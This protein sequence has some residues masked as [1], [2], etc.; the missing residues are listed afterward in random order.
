[1][2]KGDQR[3]TVTDYFVG[4][5]FVLCHANI[6]KV[7]QVLISEKSA[8][9]GESNG[10]IEVDAPELFGGYD[11]EGGAIGTL[12]VLDGNENQAP[13]S[14][15]QQ[16]IGTP[17]PAYRGITTVVAEAFNVG[18]NYYM[19]SWM[20]DVV[21]IAKLTSGAAQ[22]NIGT[23]EV[24]GAG[25]GII[26]AVHVIM[27][28]YTD[29]SW[30]K[31]VS[32][33]DIDTAS[34]VTAA[35]T[36]YDEG[37]GFS[38]E[39]AGKKSL[40]D[41]ILDVTSHIQGVVRT[42][43]TTQQI[44]LF[45]IR[46]IVDTSGLLL[47]DETNIVDVSSITKRELDKRVSHLVIK[48]LPIGENKE[49]T[50]TFSSPSLSLKQIKPKKKTTN[51]T[52]VVT[53]E[54]AIKLGN[55]DMQQLSRPI[56]SGSFTC[57]P[58]ASG[59]NIGDAFKLNHPDYMDFTI[60]CRVETLGLG[61]VE[62]SKLTLT[63]SED[64]Y[65]VSSAVYASI[66]ASA[67]VDPIQP[68]VNSPFQ[69]VG[70]VPYYRIAQVVGDAEARLLDYTSEVGL[71]MLL[72]APTGDTLSGDMYYK[73]GGSWI[74][75]GGYSAQSTFAAEITTEIDQL[76]ATVPIGLVVGYSYLE[77]G[78]ILVV[79]KEYMSVVTL[80]TTSLVV[81]RGVLSSYPRV[82]IAGTR[83]FSLSDFVTSSDITTYG[84][85]TYEYW[86]G[87]V[88]LGGRLAPEAGTTGLF[89]DPDS[90]L[91]FDPYPPADLKIGGVSWLAS[92]DHTLTMDVSWKSRN[93]ILQTESPIGYYEGNITPDANIT[94]SG[95][96]V[97]DTVL[98]DSFSNITAL[99]YTFAIPKEVAGNCVVT[100]TSVDPTQTVDAT[101]SV[102]HTLVLTRPT[103][104]LI[105]GGDRLMSGGSPLSS[106]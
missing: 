23:A 74:T 28:C 13:N 39:W 3:P 19:K 20:F 32:L 81:K 25:S 99:N 73:T 60:I 36:C 10:T 18:R 9:E 77:V 62:K 15:L 14:Y 56:F 53:Q 76:T 92:F 66:E 40:D 80:A 22:W 94:Y 5:H 29:T 97:V 106:H 70:V 16:I 82:H 58:E 91:P 59:L 57:T 49:E 88:S 93:R 87:T 48:Y 42:N 96:L 4:L 54:V 61:T 103:Y 1:M 31:G 43:R 47:L 35:Q 26:N 51:Y 68:P 17:I 12:T 37:L 7:T 98:I 50:L 46:E 102:V 75:L 78:D 34:F 84:L 65:S 100:I 44:E 105:S 2:S 6:D 41:F 101:S 63:F 90:A 83:I 27:E 67:W 55:R 38:F 8:W 69:A 95:T 21:R 64:V 86:A 33:A 11:K 72:A 24:G 52:G 89:L 71:Y 45:L 30:G 85:N 104:H 79:G